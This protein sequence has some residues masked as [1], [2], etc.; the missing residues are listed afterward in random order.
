MPPQRRGRVDVLAA[1]VG[2]LD[3]HRRTL[4]LA[5]AAV[6]APILMAQVAEALG[7]DWPPVHA[8]LLA[9]MLGVIAWWLIEVSLVY[10][11]ALWETEHDRLLRDRGLPR[12]VLLKARS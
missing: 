6:V 11:T 4:S 2:W 1:R 12:A 3:R 5:A 8:A 9:V 10:V 7:T